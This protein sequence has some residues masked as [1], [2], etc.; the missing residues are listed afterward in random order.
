MAHLLEVE[1]LSIAFADD[2]GENTYVDGVSFHVD[3]GE[4]VCIVGESGCGKSVTVLSMMGLLGENGRVK[5]GRVLLNGQNLL[6]LSETAF[7]RVRGNEISMIF[8]DAMSSLNPVFTIG[9]QLTEAIRAHLRMPK[10]EA[11]AR[12]VGLLDKVGLSDPEKVMRKYPHTLS[13]GMRQRVMIAMALACGP[14]L[15]IADEPT[16]ALDVTIQAQIMRLIRKLTRE[17]HMSL[18]LITH[19]MGLVAE[20]ADRVLV[21]YA[22]QIVESADVRSLFHS[23]MHPYTKALLQSM[24]NLLEGA[25]RRLTSIRGTVPEHY[26]N[27][28]GCRFFNRCERAVPACE[29]MPQSMA[30]AGGQT[31]VRC[32]LAADALQTENMNS[33]APENGLGQAAASQTNVPQA[34]E[35]NGATPENGMSQTLAPRTEAQATALPLTGAPPPTA[36]EQPLEGGG[37]NGTQRG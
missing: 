31:C 15:L 6:A 9:N 19:D 17:M 29:H 20:M 4:T 18:L 16:T 11:E 34:D 3:E 8:Q 12:A 35:K 32:W 33:A 2:F 30:C 23:P 36:G 10:K 13:G 1:G 25:G 21:M 37:A 22:G 14:K 27:I 7:D 5:Q 24:P 26:Q 28:D